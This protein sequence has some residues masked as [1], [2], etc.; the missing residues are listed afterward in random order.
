MIFTAGII[1][2]ALALLVIRDACRWMGRHLEIWLAR[3]SNQI[4]GH[5][6]D[7]RAV[8]PR[9]S[10]VRRDYLAEVQARQHHREFHEDL[11]ASARRAIRRFSFLARCAESRVG[12]VP[13][14]EDPDGMHA[15][16]KAR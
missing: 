14:R 13:P 7:A 9:I 16:A 8:T 3:S 10:A 5:G 2:L 1:L 4:K 15:D 12:L 6:F 11:F